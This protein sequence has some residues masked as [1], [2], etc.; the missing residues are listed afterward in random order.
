MFAAVVPVRKAD[1]V[2]EDGHDGHDSHDSH[3]FDEGYTPMWFSTP[4]PQKAVRLA[5]PSLSWIIP[6][7]PSPQTTS[8]TRTS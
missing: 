4:L 6:T 8:R 5:T 1:V 7:I 2:Y 3:P